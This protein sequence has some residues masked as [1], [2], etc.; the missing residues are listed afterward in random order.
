MEQVLFSHNFQPQIEFE[1]NMLIDVIV[2]STIIYD[3]DNK[4][5]REKCIQE[6]LQ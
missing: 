4:N 6:M 2:R 1:T 5:I 3:T